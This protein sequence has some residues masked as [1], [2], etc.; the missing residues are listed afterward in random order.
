MLMTNMSL[1]TVQ[2][3]YRILGETALDRKTIAEMRIANHNCCILCG[4]TVAMYPPDIYRILPE[5]PKGMA[6]VYDSVLK[7]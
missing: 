7:A 1:D 4:R 3:A 6:Q 5:N 2:D